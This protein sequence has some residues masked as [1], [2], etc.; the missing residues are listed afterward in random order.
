MDQQA[1][2]ER[3]F[4]LLEGACGEG[5]F[6]GNNVPL[7]SHGGCGNLGRGSHAFCYFLCAKSKEEGSGFADA[8]PN[9]RAAGLHNRHFRP[10]GRNL[11]NFRSR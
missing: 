1:L 4:I 7:E 8:V 9:G 10:T 6:E 5:C 11:E 3:L 2:P